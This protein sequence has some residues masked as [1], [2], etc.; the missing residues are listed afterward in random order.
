MDVSII[1]VNYNVQHFLEQALQSVFRS[2]CDIKYEVILIDNHSVDGSIL[3]VRDRFPQVIVIENS[4]NP[5]FSKA[6]NQGIKIAKGK[7]LLLLNP[8][9][10]L[11]EGTLQ[12]CFDFMEGKATC[13]ALTVKMIDGSGKYL[14]ES[15]RGFPTPW[16]AFSKMSGLSRLFPKSLYFNHYYLGHLDENTTAEV[17]VLPGAFMW[18]RRE[19]LEKVGLLDEQFFMYG[20]DIDLSYRIN[21]AGFSNYYLPTTTIIHFK[22]ESTKKGSFNY[23]KHF[24]LAMIIFAQKHFK[25]RK[26]SIYIWLINV[27]I[28]L[29]ALVSI[30]VQ[31]FRKIFLPVLDF[32]F[33]WVGLTYAHRWWLSTLDPPIIAPA[34]QSYWPSI[35][36]YAAIWVLAMYINGAY[37]RLND[38]R[39]LITSLVIGTLI[40]S[41]FFSIF[42]NPMLT[43][44]F[45]VLW[46]F[47][48]A[49]L[50]SLVTRILYNF[51]TQRKFSLILT[52]TKKIIIVGKQEAA[53]RILSLLQKVNLP[54]QL[55]G[56]INSD[57]PTHYTLDQSL[58]I[59]GSK[60]TIKDILEIEKPNEIIFCLDSM[61]SH[62]I[63]DLMV[64]LGDRIHFKMASEDS[65]SIIGSH[66]KN[67]PGELYT[68]DIQFDIMDPTQRRFKFLL[69][70]CLSLLT[71]MMLPIFMLV[72][73]PLSILKN[74]FFVSF[75]QSTWV[76]YERMLS[77]SKNISLPKI[78]PSVMSEWKVSG[79]DGSF[80]TEMNFNY[81]KEYSVWRDL[82]TWF[83]GF[84]FLGSKPK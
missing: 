43:S 45:F 47:L 22:G 33:I 13:G 2:I 50:S 53:Q 57:K 54:F 68:L 77:S 60:D 8:D 6:N 34:T 48:L 51:I 63:I 70:L 74:I 36:I 78:L 23:V 40:V 41:T 5:G 30:T 12:T 37:D 15:K 14:P 83:K 79:L 58:R 59:L 38:F 49:L 1:I 73:N 39:K 10:I 3:M 25:G 21:Q 27:A 4:N 24:Y 32:S 18:I 17:E 62:E 31:S 28:Y 65:I 11:E 71:L 35:S 64:D 56:I 66:S 26:A 19:A 81:A 82:E 20:E 52:N 69:D 55:L 76:G 61:S 84:K 9:T 75:R 29:R 46:G 72:H 16:A 67:T 44:R 42:Y 7:Y 80:I